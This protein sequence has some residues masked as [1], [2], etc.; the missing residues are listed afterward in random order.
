MQ[1][2]EKETREPFF[3]RVFHYQR[4]GTTSTRGIIHAAVRPYTLCQ[5]AA[6]FVHAFIYVSM[7]SQFALNKNLDNS[8]RLVTSYDELFA[9]MS[10]FL[11]DNNLD[12]YSI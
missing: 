3:R 11:D 5:R 4:A 9:I 1:R 10:V 12:N 6:V 2:V 8:L 7:R